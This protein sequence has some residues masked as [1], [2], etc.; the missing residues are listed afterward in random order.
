MQFEIRRLFACNG[1][2]TTAQ[3]EYK[4]DGFVCAETVSRHRRLDLEIHRIWEN[5]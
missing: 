4:P 3:T 2:I 5:G 1:Q